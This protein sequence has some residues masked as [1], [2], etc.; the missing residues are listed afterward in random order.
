MPKYHR[1]V[2]IF[3]FF[4]R[5]VLGPFFRLLWI[6]EITGINNIPREGPVIIALNHE[7]YFDF[8]CFVAI[9]PRNIHFL[10]AEKFFEKRLWNALMKITGQIRVDRTD[11]DKRKVHNLVFLHLQHKKAIGIFPEGTRAPDK[12]NLLKGYPGIVRYA[13]KQKVPI[14]PVGIIG[15][16]DIMSREDYRPAFKKIV[17]INIG[18][19]ISFD[20]YYHI[21]LNQKAY[22]FFTHELM[23]E[24]S[25]LSRKKYPY[26]FK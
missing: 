17:R 22:R 6:K 16:F 3:Y 15:T 24:I 23:Q 5:K 14:I 13:F 9:S 20:N 12:E 4:I 1:I 26:E 11:K 25:R 7:S 8:L 19:P 18:S 10:A 21:K 2:D